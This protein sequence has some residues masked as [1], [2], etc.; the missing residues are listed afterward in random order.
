[1]LFG[2]FRVE[3]F[4]HICAAC[5][6]AAMRRNAAACAAHASLATSHAIDSLATTP[7]RLLRMTL[8]R[9]ASLWHACQAPPLGSTPGWRCPAALW[10]AGPPGARAPRTLR[11]PR[12]C[13]PSRPAQQHAVLITPFPTTWWVRCPSGARTPYNPPNSSPPCRPSRPAH[14]NGVCSLAVPDDLVGRCPSGARAPNNPPTS[15]PCRPSCPARQHFFCHL[16]WHPK[17]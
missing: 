5:A 1:M 15:S 2:W 6:G 3:N 16:T 11:P 9:R 8:R 7:G 12:P 14:Q 10:A 17:R 13:R 4:S